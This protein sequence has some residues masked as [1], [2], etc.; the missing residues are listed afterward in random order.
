MGDE[1]S[2]EQYDLEVQITLFE[3]VMQSDN[4]TAMHN[5]KGDDMLMLSDPEQIFSALNALAVEFDC[6][7][8]FLSV[9]QHLLVIPTYDPLGK[10]MWEQIEEL[11]HKVTVHTNPEL[12]LSEVLTYD[13][14]KTLLS[15]KGKEMHIFHLLAIL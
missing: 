10:Q 2:D 14:M 5:Y 8:L 13:K 6:F 11:V 1:I 7:G 12:E 9:L 15:V 4:N 3:T